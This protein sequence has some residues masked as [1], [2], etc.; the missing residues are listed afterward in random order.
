MPMLL[1]E[2]TVSPPK[3]G[4]HDEQPSI[5]PGQS[6]DVLSG[7]ETRREV[8]WAWLA[9]TT[10]H[11]VRVAIIETLRAVGH[12][13]TA[14]DI[15]NSLGADAALIETTGTD[16]A[17]DGR[18]LSQQRVIHHLKGLERIGA[19]AVI[20]NV[21]GRPRSERHYILTATL[22]GVGHE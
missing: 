2:S 13:A 20:R 14:T 12:P 21:P 16:S 3:A 7:G 17:K 11:P 10:I 15:W 5:E 4:R 22:L 9:A 1:F 8:D 18:G 19:L 6:R